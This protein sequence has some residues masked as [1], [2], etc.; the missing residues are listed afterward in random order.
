MNGGRCSGC[1]N[2]VVLGVAVAVLSWPQQGHAFLP[3]MPSLTFSNS[4]SSVWGAKSSRARSTALQM[5]ESVEVLMP[6]LS[7]TMTE[8]KIV[9]WTKKVGDKVKSGDTLMVVES[10]KVG[11]IDEGIDDRFVSWSNEK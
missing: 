1:V 9:Q 2:L 7:S 3:G 6:A 4:P 10:D 5:A 8:G 11:G